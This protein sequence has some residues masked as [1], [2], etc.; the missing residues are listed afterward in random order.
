MNMITAVRPA[1]MFC[2][3]IS[4][5]LFLCCLF[6]TVF[7]ELNINSFSVIMLWSNFVTRSSNGVYLKLTKRIFYLCTNLG[8][9]LEQS[10]RNV[11]KQFGKWFGNTKLYFTKNTP[12]LLSPT[13]T[14]HA[15]KIPDKLSIVQFNCWN[16]PHANGNQYIFKFNPKKK[17][18]INL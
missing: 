13:P 15:H 10:Y 6:S 7:F 14:P 16:I 12:P 5:G 18:H 11:S 4:E 17:E 2:T 9:Q 3:F 8:I 1:T